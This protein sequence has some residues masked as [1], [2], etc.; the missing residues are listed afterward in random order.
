MSVR[1]PS[2]LAL[3]GALL[4]VGCGGR[5]TPPSPPPAPAPAL[6]PAAD[7][8]PAAQFPAAPEAPVLENLLGE[9]EGPVAVVHFLS[10]GQG[11]SALVQ[12]PNGKNILIDAGPPD[13]ARSLLHYLKDR[14]VRRID[15]LVET[16]PHADHIGGVVAVLQEM[17]IAQ[18]LVSGFVHPTP[19]YDAMLAAFEKKKVQVRVARRGR[20]VDVDTDTRMHV[21]APEEPFINGSR[22]DANANS[23]VIVLEYK[24]MRFLFTGDAEEE[25]EDRLLQGERERLPATV[26]KVAHHGS[27]YATSDEFLSAVGPRL[28]VVSCGKGNRYGHP[29]PE[30]MARLR[31]RGVQVLA[32]HTDG[33]VVMATDGERLE[34]YTVPRHGGAFGGAKRWPPTDPVEREI[35]LTGEKPLQINVNSATVEEL[36]K[37]PGIGKA[38][39]TRIVEWRTSRGP[40]TSLEE[41]TRVKGIGAK[42]LEK[43]RPHI[44]FWDVLPPQSNAAPI[45]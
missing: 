37:L 20:T 17:P 28:A 19:I 23:V 14:D 45:H 21:L 9:V 27:K 11:D 4:F 38:T 18:V 39:A 43:L 32:T 34:I 25:T 3:F 22:S 15:L 35:A 16:H 31:S 8:T 7:S 10:I 5:A 1:R 26:L 29:A 30:T 13:G 2:L 42:A 6:P 40:F 33:H 24:G 36:D 41:L 12:T 44:V